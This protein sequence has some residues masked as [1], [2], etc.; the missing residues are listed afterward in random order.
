MGEVASGSIH[1]IVTSPPY[2]N[3]KKYGGGGIGAKESYANYLAGLS[4]VFAECRRVLHPGRFMAVN[5]GTALFED[6]MK[7]IPSDVIRMMTDMGFSFKREILWVKPKG[8]QGLWQRTTTKFLKKEPY[9]CYLNVNVQHE[10]ILI[11]Q[12]AG[13]LQIPRT[14]DT[15]LDEETIKEYAWS[16]WEMRV[17]YTKG[18]P[19]P[20][21]EELPHRLIRLYTVE[22]ET[23]LDPFGGSGTTA[24]AAG[25][26]GRH[27]CLYEINPDY[28][29]LIRTKL[30]GLDWEV[31]VT[32]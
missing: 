7:H 8:T 26:L 23:V 4:K 17:S 6:S 1:L 29:G 19:A 13:T 20:F 27:S 28:V 9:P 24:Q 32:T 30:N 16:V 10:Y 11:F 15:R 25:K 18:H 5:I 22:G 2:W 31:E 12:K 14:E 21:P 3:L